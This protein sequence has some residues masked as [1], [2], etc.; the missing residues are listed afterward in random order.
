MNGTTGAPA[1]CTVLRVLLVEDN[2]MDERLTRLALEVDKQHQFDVTAVETLSAG[3]HRAQSD[4]FDAIILDL[5]LPD[6]D[7][8]ANVKEIALASPRTPIVVLT[9]CDEDGMA[10]HAS[11]HGAYNYLVKGKFDTSRLGRHLRCAIARTEFEAELAHRAHYDSLTG[12]VNRAL[13]Y[14]RLNHALARARRYHNRMAVL[15][16]DIDDFKSI[17]DAHG[18]AIG[19]QVLCVIAEGLRRAVRQSD[20]VARMGG[21]EFTILAEQVGGGE[22][23]QLI[24]QKILDL[25]GQ[26]ILLPSGILI[27]V[28][29]SVGVSVFP[30]DGRDGRALIDLADSAMLYAKRLGGKRLL[31]S[32]ARVER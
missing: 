25:V 31:T 24:A 16:V 27:E 21:D 4:S 12:L 13:F 3:I 9:S 14:D 20:T 7:G 23:A 30:D 5:Q 19:D 28:G 29:L 11:R 17:N 15:F 26:P 10:I 1:A 6:S 22:E 2:P 18:H 8:L 32:P